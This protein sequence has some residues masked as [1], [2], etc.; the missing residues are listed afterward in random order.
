MSAPAVSKMMRR[1]SELRLITHTPYQGVT[2]TRAGEKLAL[3]I[4]RH[5]RLIELYLVQAMGYSWDAVHEEAE[6]L[7]HH[8]SEEFEERMDALLG[9]PTAC[10]HG[11]PIPTRAGTIA[12]TSN[13][14]LALQRTRERLIVRRVRDEDSELLRHLEVTRRHARHRHRVRV[15]GAVR[16]TAR[17]AGGRQARA[18]HAAGGEGCVRGCAR[19]RRWLA[20]ARPSSRT[21]SLLSHQA[22]GPP[23]RSPTKRSRRSRAAARMAPRA[24]HAE[25]GGGVS[26]GAGVGHVDVAQGAR[27]RRAGLSRRRRLHGSRQLGHRS[28]RRLGVRLPA[29][30]RGISLQPDGGAAAGAGVEA[31]HRHRPRS[32][33]GVPRSLLAAG[34]RSFTG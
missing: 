31:R 20:L 17:A 9:H 25:P 11:D 28:R 10:P 29:A 22:H 7:E 16:G 19:G 3:E 1:L 27:V 13:R 26:H 32:R 34:G 33:A 18:S 6:R 2:L 8:I 15:A 14:S 23:R 12:R 4:I 24:P 21:P 30:L 5:H